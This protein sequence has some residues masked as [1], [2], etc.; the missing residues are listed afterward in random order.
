M[1]H[2]FTLFFFLNG[3]QAAD[4][5]VKMYTAIMFMQLHYV[6]ARFSFLFCVIVWLCVCLMTGGDDDDDDDGNDGGD[7]G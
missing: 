4:R 3:F 1:R 6:Y 5:L 2:E 7:D